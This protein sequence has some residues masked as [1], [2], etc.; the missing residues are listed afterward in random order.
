MCKM[1]NLKFIAGRD[2]RELRARQ[3]GRF[4]DVSHLSVGVRCRSAPAAYTYRQM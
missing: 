1:S 2:P 3:C 4:R